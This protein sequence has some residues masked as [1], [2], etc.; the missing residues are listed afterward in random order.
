M[1]P[2]LEQAQVI[3]DRPKHF[4]NADKDFYEKTSDTAWHRRIE[5]RAVNRNRGYEAE[6]PLGVRYKRAEPSCKT[7]HV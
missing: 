4:E 1:G 2:G 5:M 7:S 3:R 6:N